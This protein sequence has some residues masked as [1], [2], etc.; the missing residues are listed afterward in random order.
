M[1]RILTGLLLIFT[2]LFM[3]GMS[4]W[5]PA[6]STGGETP[7]IPDSL[8]T[9]KIVADTLNWTEAFG[10]TTTLSGGVCLV[11]YP[12]SSYEYQP[13]NGGSSYQCPG[14]S[15]IYS[16]VYVSSG[17]KLTQV[18]IRLNLSAARTFNFRVYGTEN[19]GGGAALFDST[20]SLDGAAYDQE[21]TWY[22]DSLE[23]YNDSISVEIEDEWG[24]T[25][26]LPY[27][28][29]A[30]PIS[31]TYA[32]DF[33]GTF[34]PIESI[35]PSLYISG[36]ETSPATV[37]VEVGYIGRVMGGFFDLG[38]YIPNLQ[39]DTL[40]VGVFQPA[41]IVNDGGSMCSEGISVLTDTCFTSSGDM[42]VV[43]N[44]LITEFTPTP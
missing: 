36:I 34:S 10:G 11:Y 21:I 18:T 8:G 23:V 26:S 4:G 30:T 44:G 7:E 42:F 27:D 25:F 28:S 31:R 32:K 6:P 37:P 38:V 39:S 14:L 33:E 20:V 19:L 22:P 12:D 3:T 29:A 5:T 13:F 16:N 35:D 15:H 2:S 17:F 41:N 40:S 1:K 24:Q 9:V 43:I